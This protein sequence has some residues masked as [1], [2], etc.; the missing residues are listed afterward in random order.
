MF[1][2]IHVCTA[3]PNH[4]LEPPPGNRIPRSRA[5]GKDTWQTGNLNGVI[6]LL[7]FSRRSGR[8]A[9][10]VRLNGLRE[11]NHGPNAGISAK[12]SLRATAIEQHQRP[13]HHDGN[14]AAHLE[15]HNLRP[16]SLK[17]GSQFIHAEELP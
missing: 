6:L 10:A 9:E 14:C 12:R 5:A 4:D 15:R 3:G 8:I 16:T 2:S 1:I 7:V 11:N 17:S 13:Q